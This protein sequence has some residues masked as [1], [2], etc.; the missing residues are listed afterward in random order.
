MTP[1]Q[2]QLDAIRNGFE[3]KV[4][5]EVLAVMHRANADLTDRADAAVPIGTTMPSF[6]LANAEGKT[7]RSDDLLAGGPL[8]VSFFRGAWCPYCIAEL[9]ALN[10]ALPAI[11]QAGAEVVVVTPQT[12]ERSATMKAEKGLDLNVLTDRGLAYADRLGLAFTLPADLVAIYTKFGLDIP[13]TNG[14]DMA[15]GAD[16]GA[17]AW[18]LPMPARLVVAPDGTI[19]ERDVNPDYSI[20]PEPEATL[21]AVRR[22]AS[23]R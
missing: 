13:A 12:R 18:R 23:G 6:E 3:P 5:P 10:E 20:R 16:A 7:V 15:N 11:R 17:D 8:V 14:A 2:P 4:P 9:A 22:V 1:L 21:D 19:V